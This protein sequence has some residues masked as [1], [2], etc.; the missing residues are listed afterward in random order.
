MSA[1]KTIIIFFLLISLN[2][3]PAYAY[4]EPG[5]ISMFLQAVIA[6]VVGFLAYVT[7]YWHKFKNFIKK[8]LNTFNKKK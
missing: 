1:L 6:T 3:T 8:I 2:S 4:I 5:I 7:L